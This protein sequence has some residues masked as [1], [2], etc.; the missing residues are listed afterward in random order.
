M[1]RELALYADNANSARRWPRAQAD[2]PAG[3]SGPRTRN[4]PMN[5]IIRYGR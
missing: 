2:A 5:E 4:M 1:R 3:G